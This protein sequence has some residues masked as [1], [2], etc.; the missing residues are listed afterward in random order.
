MEG[1]RHQALLGFESMGTS[2]AAIER[3]TEYTARLEEDFVL[4][5]QARK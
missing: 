4:L 3:L 1:I 5:A 2:A